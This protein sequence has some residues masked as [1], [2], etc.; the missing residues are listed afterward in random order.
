[1][2]DYLIKWQEYLDFNDIDVLLQTAVE[3]SAYRADKTDIHLQ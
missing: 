1:M 3:L 2:N